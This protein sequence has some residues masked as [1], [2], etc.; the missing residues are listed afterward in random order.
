MEGEHA[1]YNFD[2]SKNLQ[3]QVRLK[4]DAKLLSEVFSFCFFCFFCFPSRLF[5]IGI[6]LK[7]LFCRHFW[8]AAMER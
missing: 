3:I 7:R 4:E 2:V 8:F 6:F 5:S 1:I